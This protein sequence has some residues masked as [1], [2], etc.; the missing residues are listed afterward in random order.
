M[1]DITRSL[2]LGCH[3]DHCGDDCPAKD[4]LEALGVIDAVLQAAWRRSGLSTPFC[5]LKIAVSG[6]KLGSISRPAL[7]VLDDLTQ[8]RTTSASVTP[9]A[10]VVAFIGT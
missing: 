10:S 7:S 5:K 6:F 2:H 9:D 3:I 1:L 8:K 4:R